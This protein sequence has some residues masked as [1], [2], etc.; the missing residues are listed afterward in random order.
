MPG[1][2]GGI[3]GA[4]GEAAKIYTGIHQNHLAN[5]INPQYTPYQ[6]SPYA[7]KQLGLAE[8]LYS[9]RM[10]G[11]PEL[12]KNILST[13]AATLN[14]I[15]KNATD[16]SQ[17]LALGQLSQGQTNQAFNQLQTQEAQNKADLEAFTKSQEAYKASQLAMIEKEEELSRQRMAAI[18]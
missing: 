3:L 7:Q 11:A 15:G 14:N 9:G 2:I 13:Q 18:F 17:A 8:Q 6:T 4:V 12:E 1:L 5:Q 16:S 10:F